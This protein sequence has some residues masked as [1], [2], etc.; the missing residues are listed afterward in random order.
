MTPEVRPPD[1]VAL[2]LTTRD[3]LGVGGLSPVPDILLLVE[4]AGV[5]AF[6]APLPDGG[7]QGAYTLEQGE[8]FI[9]VNSRDPVVRMRFTL[10]HEFG[11]HA[12]SHGVAWDQV[13]V[14]EPAG[15]KRQDPRE[16]A[17][18]RFAAEFLAPLSGV[19]A[20]WYRQGADAATLGHVVRFAA[21]FGV[22]ATVALLRFAAAG[23]LRPPRLYHQLQRAI[24]QGEHLSLRRDLLLDPFADTLARVGRGGTRL[25]QD[26]RQNLLQ[27]L[28]GDLLDLER[29]AARL[30]TT[31]DALEHDLAVALEGDA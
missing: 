5:H 14:A 7:P 4:S 29:V 16:A 22:S 23:V 20:W 19:R 18:N 13:V 11:H 15:V 27:A 3:N 10:A 12:L 30:R 2:A 28:R 6:V 25:P 1:P 31:Q 26:M 9:L 21:A 8:P 24:E 17:A